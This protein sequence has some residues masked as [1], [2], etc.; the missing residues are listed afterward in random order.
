MLAGHELGRA[1][2]PPVLFLHGGGQTRF[3]W[4]ATLRKVADAGWRAAALDLRGHG[5]SE[6]APDGDYLLETLATDVAAYAE[7]APEPPVLV[8]ASLGGLS[9]LCYA[10]TSGAR[11]RALV[12]VDVTIAL[13][14]SGSQRI[15]D[16]MLGHPDGFS[17]L[18]EAASAVTA[19]SDGRH[20]AARPAGLLKNLRLGPDGRYRWH[21][22]PQV[23]NGPMTPSPLD[24][25]A[26]LEEHARRISVPVLLVRGVM[27]DVVS[28][29]GV[30]H[31]RGVLPQA[32]VANVAG[33]Q[34]DRFA[35]EILR[36]LRTLDN[37]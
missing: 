2:D 21:W 4:D 13:E 9:S 11:V 26:D 32:E 10:S 27:S 20:R 12:L 3:A 31:L 17:S 30:E 16:F 24:R 34:N 1:G 22:D 28:E 15:R 33:D 35:S 25:Q 19:Y 7:T 29:R 6:W 37:R 36:F 18:E 5:E 23:L 14:R 8:G